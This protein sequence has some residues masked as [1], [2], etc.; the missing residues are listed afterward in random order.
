MKL[1]A[2]T[3]DFRHITKDSLSNRVNQLLQSNKLINKIN[4][5]KD[6]SLNEDTIDM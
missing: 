5:S 6:F 3:I 1:L 2:T 4:R